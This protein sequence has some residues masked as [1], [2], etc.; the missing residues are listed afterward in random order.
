VTGDDFPSYETWFNRRV[1]RLGLR[2]FRAAVW[3]W[4]QYGKRDWI[5]AYLRSERPL[6]PED[7]EWLASFVE[8]TIKLPRGRPPGLNFDLKNTELQKALEVA[9][10]DV[11]ISKWTAAGEKRQGLNAQAIEAA[12]AEWC[13]SGMEPADFQ[14]KLT[15]RLARARRGT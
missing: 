14:E 11:S 15:T 10:F 4:R 7:R 12:V 8:G 5:A 6:S 13:P 1:E 9:A 3:Y 2:T